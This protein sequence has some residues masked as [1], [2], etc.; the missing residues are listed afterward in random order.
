MRILILTFFLSLTIIIK[1]HYPSDLLRIISE[2]ELIITGTIINS[3][4]EFFKVSI[5]TVIYGNSKLDEINVIYKRD[6]SILPDFPKYNNYEVG[7]KLLLFLS[8]KNDKSEIWESTGTYDEAEMVLKNDTIF[9]SYYHDINSCSLSD[10]IKSYNV[11]N[12][13]F[14]IINE[15]SNTIVTQKTN[16]SEIFFC[17]Y[18]FYVAL[19]EVLSSRNAQNVFRKNHKWVYNRNES[20]FTPLNGKFHKIDH[21]YPFSERGKIKNGERHGWWYF[22]NY[23]IKYKNGKAVIE[24]Y[25]NDDGKINNL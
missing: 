19:I 17:H 23:R 25:Y 13:N 15:K 21:Y 22:F 11:F 3:S 1:A 7:Q 8:K 9:F 12:E 14:E 10:F 5:D 4:E 24:E 18:D 2:S 6:R 16:D 20:G